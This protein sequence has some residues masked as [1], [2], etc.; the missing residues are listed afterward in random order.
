M[1]LVTGDRLRQT[2]RLEVDEIEVALAVCHA[3]PPGA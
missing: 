1:L 2:R 3:M